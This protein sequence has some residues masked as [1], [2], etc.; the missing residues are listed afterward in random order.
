MCGLGLRVIIFLMT[1]FTISCSDVKFEQLPVSQSPSTGGP[2]DKAMTESF[3]QQHEQPKLDILVI[4]DNSPSMQAEQKKLGQRLSN[5]TDQLADV[6]WQIGVTNTDVSNGKYGMKGHLLKYEGLNKTYL[7]KHDPNYNEH[8]LETVVQKDAA[9]CVGECP[10]IDEQPLKALALAISMAETSN[11]ELFRGDSDFAVIIISDEDE[12]SDGPSSAMKPRKVMAI[13]NSLFPQKN[14][15]VNGVVVQPGDSDCLDEQGLDG[16]YATHVHEFARITGGITTSICEE[17]Y[18]SG[19][20]S[21]GQRARKLLNTVTLSQDPQPGSV[22]VQ[23]SPYHNTSFEVSGRKVVFDVPPPSGTE[24][25]VSYDFKE[26][27]INPL[28]ADNDSDDD[29]HHRHDD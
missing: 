14:M 23:F 25:I 21:I 29:K 6:D 8:F 4:V 2:S 27:P 19:L 11:Y 26:D 22:E 12:K 13:F 20:A 1:L 9:N 16:K 24:I 3:F 5:F 7:T 15:S 28:I 10:S 17:D 18:G